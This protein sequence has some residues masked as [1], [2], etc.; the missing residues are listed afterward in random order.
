[1][2]QKS[3]P[4][5][6]NKSNVSEFSNSLFSVKEYSQTFLTNYAIRSVFEV[7]FEK[8][9]CLI[10]NFHVLLDPKRNSLVIYVSVFLVNLQTRLT[11]DKIT[12]LKT[13]TFLQKKIFDCLN[14]YGLNYNKR[15]IFHNLN[16]AFANVKVNT[17]PLQRFKREQYYYPSVEL[18]KILHSSLNNSN[19]VAKFI[20][21]FFKLLHRSKKGNKFFLFLN[22][23]SKLVVLSSPHISGLKIQIKGR[24]RGAP[25]SKVRVIQYGIVPLQTINS[26]ISYTLVHAH[27]TYGAFGIRVWLSQK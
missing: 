27:T 16:K 15:F 9:G 23:F 22:I 10:K 17:K 5:S 8:K 24:L 19:I 13:S 12:T 7:L 1:M 20:V 18:L 25:R 2:G 11:S 14:Y 21:K 3:N 26:S 4:N 6:F